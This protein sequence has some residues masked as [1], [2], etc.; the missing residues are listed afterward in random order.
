MSYFPNAS[1]F[2]INRATF[3]EKQINNEKDDIF[4]ALQQLLQYVAQGATHDSGEQYDAPKCHPDT[5]KQLLSDIN[6]WIKEPD[7]ETGIMYLH[8]SAGAGKSSIARSVCEKASQSGYLGASFFFWRG[9]Q[10]RN[11]AKKLFP[12]IAYQ[13]AM[14]NNVLSGHILAEIQLNPQLIYDAPVGY[15]FQKL[16]VEPCLKLVES[17]QP[18]LYCVGRSAIVIDGLDECL[19]QTMQIA[20]LKL[21]VKATQYD[22]FPLDF[23]ITSRPE[24]HLQEVWDTKEIPSV[25]QFISLSG[26]WGTYQDIQTV[27]ESGF[28]C[29]LNNRRFKAALRS[30]PWPWPPPSSIWKLVEQSSG[31][32]IYAATVMKFI[33]SPHHNPN[34]QLEIVLGIQ[35]SRNSSPLADLDFLYHEILS[36]AEDPERTMKVL[37]YIL[38]IKEAGGG[39]SDM[40]QQNSMATHIIGLWKNLKAVEFTEALVNNCSPS[41]E[42]LESM[43]YLWLAYCERL[44]ALH[45][46]VALSYLTQSSLYRTGIIDLNL[47][48]E[49]L[50]NI[51]DILIGLDVLFTLGYRKDLSIFLSSQQFS[52]N[53]HCTSDDYADAHITAIHLLRLQF[54]IPQA[55]QTTGYNVGQVLA[56][57]K[58]K[59]NTCTSNGARICSSTIL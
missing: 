42:I 14:L 19:D 28:A 4:T 41:L 26:V 23:F 12:T 5:R 50:A 21:L 44:I 32:F 2:V 16:I 40:K 43:N 56:G 10:D 46:I 47:S 11:N 9:S 25:T 20:I 59:C 37:G 55:S 54:L 17:C 51:D 1:N 45:D 34:A 38:A 24:L 13:L 8:G 39:I 22:G 35:D 36:R 3:V 7:K 27:L 31:Q 18:P 15:Q 53:F 29:I 58:P 6:Q 49:E 57:S 52:G 48:S 33:S 30:V